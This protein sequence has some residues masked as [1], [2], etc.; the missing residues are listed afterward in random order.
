MATDEAPGGPEPP[1]R[2]NYPAIR[3][4]DE[5][6]HRG[7]RLLCGGMFLIMALM[8]FASVVTETFGNRREWSDVAI[9]AV[10][11]LMAV[12]TRAVKPGETRWP[13]PVAIGV[14]AA[15]TVVIAAAVYVYTE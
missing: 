3:R 15:A 14:A 1:W 7:E 11:C 2:P 6:W 5:L 12:R 4:L 9:L 13:L 8:V 10:V